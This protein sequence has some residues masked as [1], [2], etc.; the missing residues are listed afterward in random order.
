MYVLDPKLQDGHKIPKWNQRARRSQ[1][2]GVSPNYSSTVGLI[3]NLRTGAITTQYHVLYDDLYST[4]PN[5]ENGG[6]PD[7]TRDRDFWLRLISTGIESY[8]P[9]LDP[10]EDGA[11]PELGG[12]WMTDAEIAHRHPPPIIAP[13]LVSGGGGQAQE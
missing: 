13:P 1:Y 9:D 6:G 8:L 7:P 12:E 3:L 11:V 4:V 5:S 2:L 10:N